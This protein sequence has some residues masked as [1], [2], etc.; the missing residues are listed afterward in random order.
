MIKR[1]YRQWMVM[2]SLMGPGFLAAMADNDAGGIAMYMQAGAEYGYVVLGIVWLSIICL[3]ICQ[4]MAARIGL[5]SGQGLVA[6]I[7]QEYGLVSSMLIVMILLAANLATTVAEFVGIAI[8]GSLLGIADWLSVLLAGV[9]LCVMVLWCCYRRIERILLALCLSFVAYLIGGYE[10]MPTVV[11]VQAH[12]NLAELWEVPFWLMTIGVIGT[13]VT[14]WGQFYLQSSVVDK[15]LDYESYRYIKADVW[16]GS[17]LT[18]LIAL[19]IVCIGVATFFEQGKEYISLTQSVEALTGLFG[20][21]AGLLFGMGL[22]GASLL[23]AF[24]VPLSTAYA[25]CESLGMEY[26]LDRSWREA[27]V[28]FAVYIGVVVIGMMGAI[29][30]DIASLELIIATQVVNGILLLPILACA[31][32]LSQK[33]CV[34]GRYTSSTWQNRLAIAVLWILTIA[35]VT[36]L[37]TI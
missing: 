4:D 37:V 15:G 19:A 26:G 18:G 7:R 22:L 6:L 33:E 8:A 9:M 25:I 2:L 12:C 23:A 29:A 32:M 24:I 16:I 13:T 11:A 36:M 1:L 21:W 5:A 20:M 3:V 10:A 31:V 35:Q 14:P 30:I 34:M 17:C 28:F 27:P